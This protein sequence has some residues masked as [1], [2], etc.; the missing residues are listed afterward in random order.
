MCCE[1]DKK[2]KA[3]IAKYFPPGWKFFFDPTVGNKNKSDVSSLVK[4]LDGL[5]LLSPNGSRFYS[6]ERAVNKNPALFSQLEVPP[7]RFYD[8]VG[9]SF[10]NEEMRALETPLRVQRQE[11]L[12]AKR[13]KLTSPRNLHVPAEIQTFGDPSVDSSINL[14]AMPDVASFPSNDKPLTPTQLYQRRCRCCAR[15]RKRDCTKCRSCVFNAC[16]TRKHKEVCLR[17]VCRVSFVYSLN[18]SI[19]VTRISCA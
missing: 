13:Q 8:Y 3:Q 5:I 11:S 7:Q 19:F 17:K 12:V 6:V 14:P 1:I 4:K 16:R 18:S 9:I 15:C 2:H 10:T